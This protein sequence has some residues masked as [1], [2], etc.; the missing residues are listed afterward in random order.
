MADVAA[1]AVDDDAALVGKP[2]EASERTIC[3]LPLLMYSV[4]ANGIRKS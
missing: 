1:V 3:T 2:A 4:M